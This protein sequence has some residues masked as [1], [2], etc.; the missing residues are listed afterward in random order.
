MDS[1]ALDRLPQDQQNSL[2]KG[3]FVDVADILCRLP[4]ELQRKCKISLTEAEAI[5]QVLY[6]SSNPPPLRTL[7][8]AKQDGDEA[9]TTGDVLLDEAL[10]GGIRTGMVWEFVG[11]SSA[12]KTQFALLLSL[13]VQLPVVHK[14]LRGSTCYLTTSATLPTSRL[15]QLAQTHPLLAGST[16][17]SLG[18]VHTISVPN[19]PA[20]L[21]VLEEV[22]PAFIEETAFGL[23]QKKP[24]K[25]VVI[26][27]LAELFHEQT[28]TTKNTL[29]E[30]AKNIVL[31]ARHLHMLAGKHRLAVLVLNEVMDAFDKAETGISAS[32]SGHTLYSEQV[33][34]FG[35]AH[36]IP[37]E[38]K[39]EASL[40]LVWANQVNVRVLLS[41]TGRRRRRDDAQYQHSKRLKSSSVSE[42]PAHSS[43]TNFNEDTDEFI[44]LRRLSVIFTSVAR[45]VS[46]DYVITEAGIFTIPDEASWSGKEGESLNLSIAPPGPS[47]PSPSN[48]SE[49]PTLPP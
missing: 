23:N 13:I 8:E 25:L 33:R 5:L 22:L 27:A 24:V 9:C 49:V 29:V 44:L 45:P 38:N 2:R 34:W 15:V 6:D 16:D 10:G 14:G 28:K 32:A 39:K 40:G 47:E 18:D 11:E 1:N 31:I 46:L 42:V 41:R 30:R 4:Q 43:I 37:G 19:L 17:C 21:Q 7:A 12:G 35:R 36:S 3:G 26:D 48:T 20:L